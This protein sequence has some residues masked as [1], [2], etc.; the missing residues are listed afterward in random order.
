[1]L[2]CHPLTEQPKTILLE[3]LY[4]EDKR[5]EKSHPLH[6]RYTGLYQKYASG[7]TEKTSATEEVKMSADQIKDIF[8]KWFAESYPSVKPGNHSIIS[9]VAFAEHVLGLLGGETVSNNED[10]SNS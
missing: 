4:F 9:H 1:M 7:S 6:G 2:D 5:H 3:S 8:L 10:G